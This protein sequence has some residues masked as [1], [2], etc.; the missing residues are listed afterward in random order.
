M[1]TKAARKTVITC[2]DC[3]P[4]SIEGRWYAAVDSYLWPIVMDPEIDYSLQQK[5]QHAARKQKTEHLKA[6]SSF[7][8]EFKE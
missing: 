6:S 2:T 8:L 4:G 1:N 3:I 7:I 5:R